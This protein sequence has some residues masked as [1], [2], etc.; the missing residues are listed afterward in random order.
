MG[1]H[2]A[3][4]RGRTWG[5]APLPVVVRHAPCRQRMGGGLPTPSAPNPSELFGVCRRPWFCT[6]PSGSANRSSAAATFRHMVGT[7]RVRYDLKLRAIVGGGPDDE[8]Q[9]AILNRLLRRDPGQFNVMPT[10]P[11]GCASARRWASRTSPRGRRPQRS[12]SWGSC[13]R[14][15]QICHQLR[16]PVFERRRPLPITLA[17]T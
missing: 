15:I 8:G 16:P 17:S 7:L 5:G 4:G 3:P 13:W 6:P 9:V 10:R 14:R 12:G 11:T 1:V 2:Q